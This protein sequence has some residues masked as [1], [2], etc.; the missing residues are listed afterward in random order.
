MAKV[1]QKLGAV[2]AMNLDGG[3]ST[4]MVVGG[5]TVTKNGSSYQRR[6][7]SSLAL[8]QT[9]S[10]PES[11]PAGSVNRFHPPDY[12]I[13]GESDQAAA[14][15]VSPADQAALPPMVDDSKT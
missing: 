6:V 13:P 14:P 12:N 1:L 15:A 5:A 10:A 8:L 9:A 11:L 2:D 7:A 3:G 4:T